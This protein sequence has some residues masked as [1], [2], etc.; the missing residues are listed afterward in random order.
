MQIGIF[1]FWSSV[2]NYGQILQSFALQYFL[3]KNF[4]CS[5]EV[6]RYYSHHTSFLYKFKRIL[7]IILIQVCPFLNNQFASEIRSIR[8]RNFRE[9]KKNHIRYSQKICYGKRTLSK[10]ASKYDVLIAGSDQVWS[11]MLDDFANTV[12][13]LDFGKPSQLRISYAASF[14]RRTYPDSLNFRLSQELKRFDMI[15]VRES[16]GVEI[17]KRCGVEAVQVLDP[18]MLLRADE[19]NRVIKNKKSHSYIFLYVIN[20]CSEDDIYWKEIYS[21]IKTRNVVCTSASGYKKNNI[22]LKGVIYEYSTVDEWLSNIEFSDFVITTSFHGVAF[23]LIFRK[24]FVYIPLKGDYA[25]SNNRVLD[26][27]SELRLESRV[28]HNSANFKDILE[29]DIDYNIVDIKL[30]AL[31]ITSITYLKKAIDNHALVSR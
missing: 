29:E 23:S 9:F 1:T 18:T 17:C 19:Y 14:G 28:L 6:I 7:K 3:N 13:Y 27:L 4:D 16:D 21:I 12:Y 25:E 20:I 30:A 11:M 8:R 15:S 2:D 10:F 5:A 26:L 22:T 31:R 24:N